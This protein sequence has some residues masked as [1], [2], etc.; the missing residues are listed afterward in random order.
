MVYWGNGSSLAMAT[1]TDNFFGSPG[2]FA[3]S[4]HSKTVFT[5]NTQFV[6]IDSLGAQS[7]NGR[8][9]A[10]FC[11]VRTADPS[12]DWNIFVKASGTPLGVGPNGIGIVDGN[13]IGADNGAN[14]DWSKMGAYLKNFDPTFTSIATIASEVSPREE[15]GVEQYIPKEGTRAHWKHPKAT[16]SFKLFERVFDSENHDHW[17]DWGWP[18]APLAHLEYDQTR[19][20]GGAHGQYKQFDANGNYVE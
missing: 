19:V 8:Y 3:H 18:T 20:M 2:G 16:G 6:P 13:F 1:V 10:N 14:W 15:G 11:G 4:W 12:S 7:S 5:Y 9:T 17:L